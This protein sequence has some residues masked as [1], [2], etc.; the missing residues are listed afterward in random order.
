VHAA[1]CVTVGDLHS[2]SAADLAATRG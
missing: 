2:P 1:R